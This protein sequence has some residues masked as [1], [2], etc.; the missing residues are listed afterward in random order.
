MGLHVN[1]YMKTRNQRR[2][3]LGPDNILA[4]MTGPVSGTTIPGSARFCVCAKSPLTGTWGDSNCGG[5]FGPRLK[6]SG[7]DGVFL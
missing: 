6:K 1:I 5:A 4:I 3:R 2:M 7:F